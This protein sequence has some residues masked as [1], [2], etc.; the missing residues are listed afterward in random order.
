LCCSPSFKGK[1]KSGVKAVGRTIFAI[2]R[3]WR[4]LESHKWVK[5]KEWESVEEAKKNCEL[6]D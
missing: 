1:G 5:F 3:F 2:R 4:A 6:R